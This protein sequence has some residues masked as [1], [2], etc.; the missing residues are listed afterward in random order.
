M[1]IYTHTKERNFSVAKNRNK[2]QTIPQIDLDKSSHLSESS[3]SSRVKRR[4][5][6]LP[7]QPHRAVP[8]TIW[9][10]GCQCAL[11]MARIYSLHFVSLLLQR[12]IMEVLTGHGEKAGY[13]KSNR[14][15]VAVFKFHYD[16][17]WF[18]FQKDCFE[19]YI[20]RD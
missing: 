14:K 12:S 18:T 13:F 9:L 7:S 17:I 2:N 1:H 11:H 16:T 8:Q 6:G 5:K 15:A 10:K 3:A 20:G 19:I 4:G